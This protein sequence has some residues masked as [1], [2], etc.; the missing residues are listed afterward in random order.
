MDAFELLTALACTTVS[1]LNMLF[2]VHIPM[3]HETKCAQEH[4]KV[5]NPTGLYKDIPSA[6]HRA[7]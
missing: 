2:F 5:G 3:W 7:N 6:H 1:A 4:H